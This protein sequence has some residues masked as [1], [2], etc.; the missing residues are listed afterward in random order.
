V[1]TDIL[2]HNIF[3]GDHDTVS[4]S[5]DSPALDIGAFAMSKVVLKQSSDFYKNVS[6][7]I[8]I[9]GGG[10]KRIGLIVSGGNSIT[11]SMY[12]SCSKSGASDAS[13]PF[14]VL[15]GSPFFYSS[16]TAA[17]AGDLIDRGSSWSDGGFQK[18]TVKGHV[19]KTERIS[20][21]LSGHQLVTSSFSDLLVK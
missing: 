18:L 15:S 11:A 21:V 10:E 9:F 6:P 12:V 14:L 20:L 19:S 3:T 17:S 5:A 4:G 16:L 13:A 2:G 1:G 7:G 8:V